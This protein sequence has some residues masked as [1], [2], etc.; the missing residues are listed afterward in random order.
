MDSP[1]RLPGRPGGMM[2]FNSI[3][4]I[5]ELYVRG[6]KGHTPFNSIEWIPEVL[7]AQKADV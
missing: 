4:W 2:S 7:P 5:L 1:A 6:F 3:E